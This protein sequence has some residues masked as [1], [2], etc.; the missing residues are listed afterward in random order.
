MTTDWVLQHPV[1]PANAG[2]QIEPLASGGQDGGRRRIHP[3]LSGCIWA[4]TFVGEVAWGEG[5]QSRI[6]VKL[7]ASVTRTLSP[8]LTPS[9]KEK[10]RAL[11]SPPSS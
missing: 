4:P 7:Q 9:P 2:A 1:S 8:R 11:A 6:V 3:R 5:L 10:R